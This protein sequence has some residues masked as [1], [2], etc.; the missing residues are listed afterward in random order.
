MLALLKELRKK[1][2]IG[3]V[4]GSD[5]VKVSEQLGG[6]NSAYSTH[7]AVLKAH[8]NALVTEVIYELDYT[9]AE[10]GLTAYKLG[11]E[12]PTQSFIKFVGEERYKKLVNFILHYLADIEIP[13]KRCAFRSVAIA[14]ETERVQRDVCRVPQWND[15][16]Q[17]HWA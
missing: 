4:G 17:P 11:K 2:D 7:T 5:F 8:S 1:V 15:Q 13:I 16:R 6:P 14:A 12:P 3:V 9:F 10:N